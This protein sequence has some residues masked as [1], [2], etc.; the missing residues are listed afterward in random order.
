MDNVSFLYDFKKKIAS[1]SI[2]VGGNPQVFKLG[3]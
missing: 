3:K 2:C 1:K